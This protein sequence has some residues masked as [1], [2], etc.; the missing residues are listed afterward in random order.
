MNHLKKEGY[1]DYQIVELG[2]K[3]QGISPE[4]LTSRNIALLCVGKSVSLGVPSGCTKDFREEAQIPGRFR[5][6]V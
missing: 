3:P 2:L 5:D 6:V 1:R 4:C